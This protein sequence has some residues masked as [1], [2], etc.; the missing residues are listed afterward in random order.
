VQLQL[1][2]YQLQYPGWPGWPVHPAAARLAVRLPAFLHLLLLLLPADRLKPR[3]L[4]LL[5][6]LVL[7][8]L[9]WRPAR[10]AALLPMRPWAT[11]LQTRP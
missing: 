11:V 8:P 9:L 10:P 3:R 7:L 2:P 1:Q 4:L 6:L 5:L